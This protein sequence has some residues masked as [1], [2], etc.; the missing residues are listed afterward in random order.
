MRFSTLGF[1]SSINPTQGPDSRAKAVLHMASKSPRNLR[2]MRPRKTLPRFQWDHGSGF[3]SFNETVE[4][5]SAVLM[6]SLNPLK[7]FNKIIFTQKCSFQN[8]TSSKKVCLLRSLWDRGSGFGS[9]NET[10]EAGSAVSMR[11]RNPLWHSG[12]PCENEYWLSI[13]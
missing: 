2:S 7:N 13:L 11:P 5:A 3:G 8:K 1:F 10:A 4:A 12:R 9:L 6:R